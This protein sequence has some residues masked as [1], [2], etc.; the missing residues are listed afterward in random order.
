MLDLEDDVSLAY[1]RL[2]RTFDGSV[3]LS[4]G[5]TGTLTG[6]TA[7][8]TK[9]PKD[10]AIS[11]LSEVIRLINDRFGT[12][13]SEEDRLLMEQVVGDLGHDEGLA[14]QARSNTLANFRHVFDPRAME[15]IIER[16]ERNQDI[17]EQFMANDELRGMMLNAMMHEFY[18]RARGSSGHEHTPSDPP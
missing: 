5:D 17:T 8:G 11:P 9:R 7:V 12:E 4:P 3:S 15:A 6:P 13:F 10:E 16:M 1:Y 2:E 18:S 14:A